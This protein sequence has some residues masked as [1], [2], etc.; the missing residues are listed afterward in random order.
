[1]KKVTQTLCII[2]HQG[3][4]LLGRKKMGMGVGRWTGPGGHVEEG[5]TIEEAAVREV[6]EEID[7]MVDAVKKV[8]IL[9]FKSPDTPRIEAHV[10]VATNFEGEPAET[11]EMAPEWFTK[12]TLPFMNMWPSDVYW[13]PHLLKNRMFVGEFEFDKNDRVVSHEVKVVNTPGEID[14]FSNSR[15][16]KSD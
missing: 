16:K 1:M 11:N 2:H 7:V 6:K 3:R 9:N 4:I 12:E 15:A 14:A 13:W 8:G 10:F 5:E